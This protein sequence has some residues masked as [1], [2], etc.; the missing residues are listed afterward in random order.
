MAPFDQSN[1]TIRTQKP[2]SRSMKASCLDLTFSVEIT[3]ARIFHY[4]CLLSLQEDK[5]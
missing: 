4:L 3:I 2:K 5:L 1:I